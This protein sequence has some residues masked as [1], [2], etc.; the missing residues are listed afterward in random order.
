MFGSDVGHEI[1]PHEGTVVAKRTPERF[2]WG[3]R[4]CAGRRSCAVRSWAVV[5]SETVFRIG[6]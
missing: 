5:G 4:F 3:G 6:P 2:T 1:L